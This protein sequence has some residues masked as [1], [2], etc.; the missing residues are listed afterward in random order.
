M[1]LSS[2][3]YQ[4]K[5]LV[6]VIAWTLAA[7]LQVLTVRT[8]R[9]YLTITGQL[10][11]RG[12]SAANTPLQQ[13]MPAFAADGQTWVRHALALTEGKSL[14][15]RHTNI[16][17]APNGREVHWN[18]AWAW[19]IAGAGWVRHLF[20]GEPLP[21]AV[22]RASIWLGPFVL[23]LLT[24]LLSAWVTS[25]AGVIA[26]V[27]VVAAMT[28]SDRIYEGFFPTYVDHHGLLTV[29]VF[30]MTLGA[31]F[32][33][34]GWWREREADTDGILP[35][36]VSAARIAA[37]FSGLSGACGLWV[38]AAS[39][40]PPVVLIATAGLLVVLVHGRA[41]Q[42]QGARFEP[43]IWRI[44][45]RS[46]A[47]ASVL[48]YLLEYFPGHL[49]LRLE[50]NHPFHA[51]AWLAGGELVAQVSSRWLGPREQRW[52]NLTQFIW[53]ILAA[54]I[55]PLTIV[56]G[57]ARVF[58]VLDPFMATL[59]RD[60]IQEFLPIWMTVRNFDGRAMFQLIGVDNIPLVLGIATL[61]YQRRS[62]PLTLW[63]ATAAALLFNIMAWWQSRWLLNASGVQVALAIVVLAT[64][65]TNYRPA[66]RW[67]ACLALAGALYLPSGIM[68]Y[69]GAVSDVSARRVAPKDALCALHRDVASALRATQPAG[70]ITLLTSP[71]ASTGVGYYGRFRTLGTL[72]WE[73]G[74]GLKAAA[75]IYSARTESEAA[76]LIRKH[77]VTH[78]ALIMEE[79]FIL[80]YFSLLNP[81][82]G[83]EELKKSFGYRLLYDKVV[84]QWLQMIPYKAPDDLASLNQVIMLFKVNFRQNL[85]EALFNI[86]MS[87]LA[88]GAV[89]E[90]EQ[91]LDN[92]IRQAPKLYLP[93]LRKGEL[94]LARR[95]WNDA[96]EYLLK[97]IS[98]APEGERP[99]LY[100]S[101]GGTFYNQQQH[102]LAARV[103]RAGL[104][105]RPVAE[106]AC[107]LAWILSTSR[108]DSLRNGKEAQR[109]AEEAVKASPNSPTF[110]NSLAAALAE[111]GQFAQAAEVAARAVANAQLNNDAAVAEVSRQNLA[112]IKAGQPIRK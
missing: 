110:L 88:S 67:L 19:T 79:N 100:V 76:M 63:F 57:G 20:T 82:A 92:L 66:V 108:D 28:C 38:S 40:I 81:K 8:I 71:N 14:Q 103:Y 52:S 73:N 43:E 6:L 84:P 2:E 87:Q 89:V 85:A 109:L 34:G 64:W 80:P 35:D 58:S 72:Y 10:G 102:A 15:L 36:S 16:D 3:N 60:Y 62:A 41:A 107:Y 29:S 37:I 31:I 53:P 68:R 27:V 26:G 98:L 25:R 39:V 23:F 61:S 21:F 5:W 55:A 83:V 30:A 86:A 59:H 9:D 69:R 45:G 97:G 90:G 13:A 65:T 93:L 24:V 75:A 104:A 78:I 48:F 50:A 7:I 56:I 96:A 70:E 22:E 49:G 112:S 111:N 95:N 1:R 12:A 11:L 47:I 42:E 91:T 51:L 44:W 32:M 54:S 77:G 101:T 33:G 17:N 4:T 46:G 106:M 105:D 94:Q 74:E 18:S 99:A